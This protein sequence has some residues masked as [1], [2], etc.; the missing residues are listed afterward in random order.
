MSKYKPTLELNP[1]PANQLVG[2]VS[3]I[4]ELVANEPV[5][6]AMSALISAA[7]RLET[8]QH[9]GNEHKAAKALES[10]FKD[11]ATESNQ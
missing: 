8:C 7:H 9:S 5:W 3:K 10:V 4:E 2:L 6:L 11:I 1:T